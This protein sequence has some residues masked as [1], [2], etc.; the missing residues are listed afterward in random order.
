MAAVARRPA[1]AACAVCHNG[2]RREVAV[3]PSVQRSATR[4][5][6][7][8]AKEVIG[9]REWIALPDLGVEHIKVKVDTGARTSA[10]HAFDVRVVGRR[11]RERAHFKLHPYQRNSRVTVESQAPVVDRRQVRSSAGHVQDR[12]VI[13]TRVRFRDQEWPIEVTL[14][15]RDTMGFRMILGRQAVRGRFTVD[16]GRSYRGGRPPREIRRRGKLR[17]KRERSP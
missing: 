8:P 9:W 15:S 5:S 11:G 2:R 12:L 17:R 10:L 14:A 16:P 7:R 3:R 4:R 1:G 6:A 13:L